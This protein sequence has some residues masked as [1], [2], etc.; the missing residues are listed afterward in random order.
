MISIFIKT[1]FSKKVLS[2]IHF[3]KN[4]LF[5]KYTF[6]NIHF[7]KKSVVKYTLFQKKCYQ[8]YIQLNITFVYVKSF[9]L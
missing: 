8:K 3:F 9:L 7:F 2:N 6:S 1:T 5:Q 4:T